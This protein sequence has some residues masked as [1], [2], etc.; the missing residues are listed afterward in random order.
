MEER[1]W[2]KRMVGRGE[3]ESAEEALF[4]GFPGLAGL[5]AMRGLTGETAESVPELTPSMCAH[6]RQN[7]RLVGP[8]AWSSPQ[9]VWCWGSPCFPKL[10]EDFSHGLKDGMSV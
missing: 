4:S 6:P 8:P 2:L 9:H 7:P 5:R 1:G 10:C 3:E